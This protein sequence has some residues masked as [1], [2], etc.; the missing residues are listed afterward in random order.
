MRH[1]SAAYGAQLAIPFTL[2][3]TITGQLVSAATHAAGD[4]Q[5]Y[6]DGSAAVP[7]TNAWTING[8]TY[9][10]TLTAA[11]MQGARILVIIKDQDGPAFL[12][13]PIYIET[14]GHVNAAHML[15]NMAASSLVAVCNGT[16][17]ASSAQTD[18]VTEEDG[19]IGRLAT[20]L[21]GTVKGQQKRIVDYNVANGTIV[22]DSSLTQ[23]PAD[24]NVITI[25]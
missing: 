15:E 23:A 3:N 22:F 18:L 20:F 8:D 9:Q 19:I 7:A 11:E 10:L 4:I 2:F 5:L 21:S 1:I 13:E 14:Y 17:S 6:V 24:G 25:T 12:A 16:H